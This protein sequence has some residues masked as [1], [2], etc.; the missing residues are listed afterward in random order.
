MLAFSFVFNFIVHSSLSGMVVARFWMSAGSAECTVGCFYSAGVVDALSALR[1]R[2]AWTF[3]ARKFIGRQRNV[4]TLYL[5]Q[6]SVCQ[7]AVGA[8]LLQVFVLD[9]GEAYAGEIA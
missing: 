5:E 2:D 7:F 6:F 8:H 3:V 1:A 4:D 9:F